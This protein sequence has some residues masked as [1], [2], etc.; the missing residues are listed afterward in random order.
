VLAALLDARWTPRDVDFFCDPQPAFAADLVRDVFENLHVQSTPIWS[1]P[2]G[3]NGLVRLENVII[4]PNEHQ[5][6]ALH[7]DLLYA[8]DSA[9]RHVKDRF[10][11]DFLKNTYDGKRLVVYC[12]GAVRTLRSAFTLSAQPRIAKLL[13]RIRKYEKRGFEV[14]L[15]EHPVTFGPTLC[16]VPAVELRSRGTKLGIFLRFGPSPRAELATLCKAWAD[17]LGVGVELIPEQE[18]DLGGR[19]EDMWRGLADIH[20]VI[21][22]MERILTLESRESFMPVIRELA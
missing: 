3:Y 8:K 18:R 16:V 15:E 4:E 1:N 2:H 6:K 20:Y 9:V 14:T 7:V 22:T 21:E 10:D 17:A 12:P 11:L 13:E 5:D 19:F